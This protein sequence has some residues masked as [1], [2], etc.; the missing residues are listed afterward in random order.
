LLLSLLAISTLALAYRIQ[1]VNASGTIYIRADGSIDPPTASIYTA[2]NVT[3]VLTGDITS[4]GNGIVVERD[5]IVLNGAGYTIQGTGSGIGI[6]LAGRTSATVQDTTIK[7]FDNGIMLSSSSSNSI[8]GNNITHNKLD[9]ILLSSSSSNSIAGNNITSSSSYGVYLY[10]SSNNSI[11][12][13]NITRSSFDGIYLY[14]SSNNS[15]VGDTITKNGNGVYLRSSSSN[16]S[17]TGNTITNNGG[18]ILLENSSINAIAENSIT[19]NMD[20]GVN[21][22]SSSNNS[23]AG[24][25]ITANNFDGLYLYSSSN[26]SIAEN[27]ITVNNWDGIDLYYSSNVSIA[28]NTITVNNYYG[29]Y[30]Y[31]SSNNSIVE[32]TIT[33]S[34]DGVYLYSSSN[35]S[36]VEDTIINNGGGI[37]LD[38]SLSNSIYHNN[39]V[40]NTAQAIIQATSSNIWD[41]DYPLGGNYWSDYTGADLYSGPYQNETGSDGIGDTPYVIDPNNQDNYPLMQPYQTDVAI[42]IL[43][44]TP[45]VI[46]QGSQCSITVKVTNQD[47]FVEITITVYANMTESG[48]VTVICTLENVILDSRDSTTLT[49]MWNTSGFDLGNYTISAYATPV[50]GET[51]VVNNSCTSSS[52]QIVAGMIGGGGKMPCMN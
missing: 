46:S 50:Q 38:S 44:S 30:L 24:N 7:A 39:I 37:L 41:D 4:G 34:F 45:T 47:D 31:S 9:G 1:Q 3:Y 42:A 33:N 22:V 10:S 2:D 15:I 8:A 49:F 18:G 13:N 48:N 6:S 11:A 26:N 29:V 20:D 28:G 14:S 35:N 21:L 19:T 23:I 51:N 17:I 25:N 16:N 27:N 40:N 5:N 52:I 32:D 12:G 36:I 43:T